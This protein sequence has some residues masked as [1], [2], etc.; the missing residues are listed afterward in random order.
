MEVSLGEQKKETRLFSM[1]LQKAYERLRAFVGITPLARKTDPPVS[2][3]SGIDS[4][5]VEGVVSTLKGAAERIF[6]GIR[7]HL[8]HLS[9]TRSSYTPSVPLW[10]TGSTHLSPLFPSSG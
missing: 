9:A 4:G 1:A 6:S 10:L 3:G 7:Y 5:R 2:R 8:L